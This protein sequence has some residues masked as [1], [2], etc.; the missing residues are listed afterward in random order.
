MPQLYLNHWFNLKSSSLMSL[1]QMPNLIRICLIATT[2]LFLKKSSNAQLDTA[3]ISNHLNRQKDKLGKNFA[4]ILVKEGKVAY[5]RENSDFTLKTPQPIGASSQWLTAAL[6]MTFVQ[7]GKLSLDDKVSQYLPIFEKY[8]K[9][10]ITIRHCLTHH[11]GIQADKLFQKS[12]FKTLEE[13]VNDI[14]SKKEIWKNAGEE[15]RYSN[16]GFQ[17]AG[18]VLEALTKRTFDRLMLERIQRPCGMKNTTFANEDYNDALNPATGARSSAADFGN[19]LTMLLNKGTFNNK[20]VLTESSVETLLSL[21]VEN[22]KMKNIPASV[23]GYNYGLG[24]WVIDT[25]DKGIATSFTAPSY[26]G[27]MPVLD[28]CRK[29]GYVLL[30]K[31][32]SSP[33]GKDFYATLKEAVDAG[34]PGAG[35]N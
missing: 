9:G 5:K 17:I 6:V 21:Q 1:N 4:F 29:Y 16:V 2:L 30:T 14:A 15:A 31:D 27:S 22:N 19:F 35:C 11:T 33:P 18:R 13:E 20:P 3:A 10:Y 7:E 8:Y 32:L 26:T 28:V 23:Q 12:K 34:M 25:N 24:I